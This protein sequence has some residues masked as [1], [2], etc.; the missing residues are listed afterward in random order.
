MIMNLNINSCGKKV[1]ITFAC[2][3]FLTHVIAQDVDLLK[4]V[5]DTTPQTVKVTRAFKSTRVINSHSTEMLP[6]GTLDF[7]ILHRFGPVKNGMKDFFGLDD[8]YMRMSFD[9]G[10]TDNFMIGAGRSSFRKEYDLFGKVRMLQQSTGAKAI[11]LSL[12]IAAGGMIYTETFVTPKPDVSDRSAYYLQVIAGRK[13]SECFSLQLSPIFIHRNQLLLT[14]D[15]KNIIAVGGG[16][17]FKISKRFALTFDYYHTVSGVDEIFTDPLSVG[18]DIET[19]GHVFQL[20]F[21]NAI[22]M[23]ERAFISQNTDKFF[24][25][26]IRFGFNLS[27]VFKLGK[28][29][30]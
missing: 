7:R 19:G 1:M 3:L 2:L 11:P 26:G 18:V 24:D 27:R 5:E 17:R 16:G 13:F 21:S 9:Y 8:A 29:T 25:G 10:I 4:G 20:H 22:G 15:E 28:R 23:N 6:K 30:M 12:I 14:N